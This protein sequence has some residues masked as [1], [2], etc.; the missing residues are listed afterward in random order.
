MTDR[1]NVV[2]DIFL[3][4]HRGFGLPIVLQGIWRS[5]DRVDHV[6]FA[7]VHANLA[8]GRLGRRI[9]VPRI[10]GA[11]RR[12]TPSSDT[13][14]LTFAPQPLPEAAVLDW[15]DAQGDV[16]LDPEFGPGWR[17]SVAHIDTGG[18]VMSV[19]CSHAL[20]DAAGLISAAGAA[21]EGSAPRPDTS[22]TTSDL[23]DAFLLAT[24][25]STASIRA[26]VGLVFDR[27]ARRELD[28]FARSS[29]TVRTHEVQCSTAVFDLDAKLSNSEFI[30]LVAQIAAE[31]GE[32]DPITVNIP[33]RSKVEGA[34][35]I[36]MATVEV[37]RDDAVADIKAATTQSFGRPAGAPGGF[38][39]EAV[40]LLS[41]KKAA[42]LTASP[43]TARVL[44]SNIGP[45]PGAL[46]SLAAH[47]TTALATR[48]IH[49]N[50]GGRRTATALSAYISTMGTTSTLSL[51][52]T[53]KSY[54]PILTD[55]AIAVLARRGLGYK[56]W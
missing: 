20:A 44:C 37:S 27:A 10:P 53:E 13:L 31:L 41:E 26:V 40:Q 5:T 50:S 3:R 32:A 8:L 49:P 25:V 19:V 4:T 9:A 17:M 47:R 23:V 14:P 11:R 38:P 39:A 7:A 2:D 42:A 34:N 15:A 1:L 29:R 28:E 12:W 52:G 55:R 43:G 46:E 54:E 56:S 51:V 22:R 36:G 48:A 35:R 30:S 18:T 6:D 21:F 45:I 24:R 16:D 33:F